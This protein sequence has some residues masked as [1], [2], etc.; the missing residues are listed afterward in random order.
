MSEVVVPS[1]P[2]TM[3]AEE[4]AQEVASSSSAPQPPSVTELCILAK[5]VPKVKKSGD[6]DQDKVLE[7]HRTAGW[8]HP[9]FE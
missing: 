3:A 2:K 7:D 8:C 4:V 9:A 5:R 1:I 6:P